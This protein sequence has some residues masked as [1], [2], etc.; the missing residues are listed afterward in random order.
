M[1]KHRR[2]HDLAKDTGSGFSAPP[3]SLCNHQFQG[4]NTAPTAVTALVMMDETASKLYVTFSLR[5]TG[6]NQSRDHTSLKRELR[7]VIFAL[8]D[9]SELSKVHC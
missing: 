4:H 1:F 8:Y 7:E 9:V 3:S 2:S 5:L 6:K